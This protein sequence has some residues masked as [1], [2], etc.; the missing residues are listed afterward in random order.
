MSKYEVI[1]H[2]SEE[3][4]SFIADVPELPG[5]IAHG[6]RSKMPSGAR[7]KQSDSGSIPPANSVIR[8]LNP[9]ADV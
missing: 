2:W 5:C 6:Q 8:F 9:K 4:E 7:R 3:D 1:I